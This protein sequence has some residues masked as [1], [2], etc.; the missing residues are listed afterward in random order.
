MPIFLTNED[1]WRMIKLLYIA[2]NVE[3]FNINNIG[4][5][6]I[7]DTPRTDT[8][9]D[10]VCYCLMP[11][12]I[13]IAL[14]SKTDLE[15]DPGITK[16]MLK[17][18]TGYTMYF[19]KKHRHSGTIWQGPYKRKISDQEVEYMKTLINYI[20]LNPY[21]IKEPDMTK[22]ARKDHPHEAWAYSLNYDFSSLMDYL[23]EAKPREQKKILCEN[24]LEK[25]R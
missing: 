8:L 2:N 16:F 13:H 22:D 4:K 14:K 6:N 9:V 5:K 7:F 12:H 18:C 25:W 24:E 20:H 23:R 10:I 1:Y 11:N 3:P 21:G 19:N 17:L 15:N